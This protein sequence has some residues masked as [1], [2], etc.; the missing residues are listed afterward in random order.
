MEQK[1]WKIHMLTQEFKEMLL[2]CQKKERVG[3]FHFVSIIKKK[4]KK[5]LSNQYLQCRVY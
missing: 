2:A 4:I 5:L 1:N 3:C